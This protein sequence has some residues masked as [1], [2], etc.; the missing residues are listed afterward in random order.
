MSRLFSVVV[1]LTFWSCGQVMN[2]PPGTRDV[3]DVRGNYALT[4]DDTVTLKLDVGGGTR[5]VTTHGYGG[6]ADFG[7]VNGQPL[8]LNLAEFC[9]RPEVACPSEA[10]WPKVAIDQPDL[11]ANNFA[12]QKLVVV[13]DTVRTLP[14]GQSAASFSGLVDHQ[15]DDRFLLGLNGGTGSNT[16]C[17]A[18]SISLAGG[19]FTHVGERTE[20]MT[21]YHFEDGRACS[22]DDGGLTDAGARDAGADAGRLMADGG[23]FHCTSYQVPV[24][25]V[26]PGAAVNGIAEGKVAMGFAGGC[27]FGPVVAGATL[28]IETGFTG[29]RTGDFDPPPFTP[30]EVVLPADGGAGDAGSFDAGATDAGSSDAGHDA[31]P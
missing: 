31:G 16:A 27:A 30:A 26:P 19:R 7:T 11:K 14:R 21:R 18:L 17:F 29:T 8:T 4:Y 6:I 3:R 13:N 1:V 9:A 2:G 20:M 5:T 15:Q 28:S 12:L 22:V 23:V 25:V 24:L 10:F